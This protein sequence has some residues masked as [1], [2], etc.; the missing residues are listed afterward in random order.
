M[1]EFRIHRNRGR[2]ERSRIEKKR[3]ERSR[4]E[5]KKERDQEEGG[6]KFNFSFQSLLSGSS[7]KKCYRKL[8]LEILE[9]SFDEERL[10]NRQ[11]ERK[12]ECKGREKKRN[13]RKMFLKRNQ[14]FVPSL[15]IFFTS[16]PFSSSFLLMKQ[17]ERFYFLS[18]CCLHHHFVSS[19]LLLSV[20]FSLLS[21]SLSKKNR[22]LV[23]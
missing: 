2:K 7:G 1:D 14:L 23:T 16:I 11:E 19:S 9:M 5:K 20:S 13:G 15:A 21:L 6:K 8:T 4:I 22:S 12:G 17:L 3:R 18:Y 10:P